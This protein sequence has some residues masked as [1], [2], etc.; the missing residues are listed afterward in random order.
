MLAPVEDK[1]GRQV[2]PKSYS[3]LR[4]RNLVLE[5]VKKDPLPGVGL[6]AGEAPEDIPINKLKSTIPEKYSIGY[7]FQKYPVCII[8]AGVAGL[9]TA[10]ILQDLK[11]PFE[12]IEASDRVGGRCYTH[13]FSETTKFHDYFDVGAMRFPNNKIMSR[14]FELFKQVGIGSVEGERGKLVDYK[15]KS[16]N[17][18][19][20]YNNVRVV[21]SK[22]TTGDPFGFNIPPEYINFEF[23]GIKGAA[24][25]L[26]SALNRF[27]KAIS[28]NFE[29]GWKML[30]E[31]D[32][33]STRIYLR[34]MIVD[35]TRYP[36]AEAID[37]MKYP[38]CGIPAN[39][40]QW[41]ETMTYSS[42]W[43]DRGFS[44]TVLEDLDFNF[45]DGEGNK[46]DVS[47]YCV[48]G[49]TE[50]VTKAMVQYIKRK[51]TTKSK[52]I[53]KKRRVTAIFKNPEG[54]PMESK[55][56]SELNPVMG[57][58]VLHCPEYDNKKYSH[59]I[60]T[61]PFSCL[62]S[63]DL[64]NAGLS[65]KQNE[66]IRCLEYAPSIKIGIKFKTRWWQQEKYGAIR[67]GLSKTDLP[68][69]TV[70]YPSYGEK[71][72]KD[73]PGVLM[74]SYAWTQDSARLGA[75][76]KGKG[77]KAEE[78]LMD[79]VYRDLALL[80]E[81]AAD[82]LRAQTIDYFA[83]DFYHNE[84]TMG[85]FAFFNPGQFSELYPEIVKPA[86][87]GN[88]HICGE[89]ASTH[90]AWIVGALE[91]AWRGVFEILVKEKRDDLIEELKNKYGVP[92]EIPLYAANAQVLRGITAPDVGV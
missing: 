58:K 69:R 5:V 64:A 9:Y 10:M 45:V 14:T 62:R 21:G 87:N 15:M 28:G 17:A 19:L 70:V 4:S 18:I 1:G 66:A 68:V 56:E 31:F 59:I 46:V 37:E 3:A 79:I 38:K 25:L 89:A 81:I 82:E 8:G 91:S 57:I 16:D 29:E 36:T 2:I 44:E 11:I 86:A 73:M 55:E 72:D 61:V 7:D 85:A 33:V 50:E 26:E 53:Y 23:N 51:Q 39:V 20:M 12:I 13:R 88:L 80:H 49:G 47:W 77:T 92:E 35:P 42:G 67:G 74:A 78:H 41:M 83:H 34:F 52:F 22:T 71:D 75:L 84:F 63:M 24:G 40:V 43:F 54:A 65:P 27:K 48:D 76:M 30:R 32:G 90:H 6:K 60:S